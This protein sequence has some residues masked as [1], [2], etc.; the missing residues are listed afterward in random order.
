MDLAALS[1]TELVGRITDLA[2]QSGYAKASGNGG[3]IASTRAPLEAARVELLKRLGCALSAE[4]TNRAAFIW[5]ASARANAACKEC[6]AE[7]RGGRGINFWTK[8]KRD[9]DPLLLIMAWNM[10]TVAK[11]QETKASC[12]PLCRKCAKKRGARL[13]ETGN[14]DL[15]HYGIEGK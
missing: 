14:V 3:M 12:L 6:G 10:A 11:L 4:V 1:P 2:A 15:K 8:D 9:P 13:L 7:P 5:L